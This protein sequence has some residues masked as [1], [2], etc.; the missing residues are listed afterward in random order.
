MK[1]GSLTKPYLQQELTF[2]RHFCLR[3]LPLLFISLA[4]HVKGEHGQKS[5]FFYFWGSCYTQ[6]EQGGVEFGG[7]A[8]FSVSRY[9]LQRHQNATF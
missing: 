2:M 5:T 3:L 9:P 8:L 6:R 7:E 4:F 1:E